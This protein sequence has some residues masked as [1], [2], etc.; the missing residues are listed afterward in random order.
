MQKKKILFIHESLNGGGA[1]K[2]FSDYMARFDFDRYDVTL[3]LLFGGGTHAESL[4]PSL[5]VITLYPGPHRGLRRLLWHYR[6]SRN[7]MLWRDVL[8]A[9]GN[10][11]FDVTASF[12]EGPALLVHSMIMNRAP[13]NVSWVHVDLKVNHWSKWVFSSLEEERNIYR[14]L[15]EIAYV[16]ESARAAHRDL[17]GPTA[18]GRVTLNL[19]EPEII[20]AR[21]SEPCPMRKKRALTLCN[22]GR[23]SYQKK[24]ARLIDAVAILTEKY[25]IDV[26]AWLVG[27]GED[28]KMLERRARDK[29]VADRIVFCGYQKN[30][31]TFISHS[32]IFV[33]TSET[34][35][36]ALVVAEALCLGK[37]VISTAV[38]GPTELLAED[39]G[40]LTGHSPEEIASAIRRMATEPGL[41]EH[42]ARKARERSAI[43]QPERTMREVYSFI[44]GNQ[45]GG[46]NNR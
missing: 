29:R 8:S 39:S 46:N 38:T 7:A 13:R 5:K 24:Q 20:R 3:L 17:F 45:E 36:F 23:L 16:S 27:Q 37:P 43:F 22:V 31:N 1:E 6:L 40:I 26:E 11:R 30:P 33:L 35:G 9:L 14:Q 34:E 12:L 15:D 42:Y 10:K 2:V 28:R 4:P 18:P 32:D 19:V 25:D 21:G 41:M 44:E